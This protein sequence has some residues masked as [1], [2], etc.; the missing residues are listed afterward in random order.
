MKAHFAIASTLFGLAL[1]QAK[2]PSDLSSGFGS[3]SIGLQLSF[4]G[5]A[6]DGLSSG[7]V[8]SKDDASKTP[9]FALTDA[10]GV[11]R[12]VSFTIMMIDTTEQGSRKL[13]YLHTDFKA[14]GEKTKL[15][16]STKPLVAYGAPG[17]FGENGKR[18]Y[19][20]LLYRQTGDGKMSD[21]PKGGDSIDV[22]QFQQKNGLQDARAGVALSVDMGG[23]SGGGG[24]GGG[25]GGASYLRCLRWSCS[26][27]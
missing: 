8:V 16:S 1:S 7:A 14:T 5:D 17:S 26:C 24:G 9:S 15:D 4:G 18:E 6:S 13:H 11:N 22:K 21:V 23:G 12:A 19:T 3:G 10:S 2:V 25:G 20:F 27:C